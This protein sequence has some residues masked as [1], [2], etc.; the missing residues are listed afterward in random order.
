MITISVDSNQV[1][2]VIKSLESLRPDDSRSPLYRGLTMA[3]IFLASK[4]RENVTNRILKTRGG[5]LRGSIGSIVG[6]E[7]DNLT[8]FVGSGVRTGERVKYANILEDGGT[9]TAKGK[10][11]TVPLPKALTKKGI[12]K[13]TANEVRSGASGYKGS[14]V[15]IGKS[16]SP[17]IYGKK[18]NGKVDALFVLKNSVRIPAF[19][20]MQRTVQEY[21]E[22]AYNILVDTMRKAIKI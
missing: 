22:E 10:M 16:G 11:L 7:G 12:L 8:G 14:F 9:I 20:Y 2:R 4:L 13:F 17:I 1:N 5:R 18:S 19:R 15:R 21:G 3:T 6:R